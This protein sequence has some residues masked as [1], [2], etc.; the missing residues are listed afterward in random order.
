[1]TGFV[2]PK[3]PFATLNPFWMSNFNFCVLRAGNQNLLNVPS[4]TKQI[5]PCKHTSLVLNSTSSSLLMLLPTLVNCSFHFH[6]Q[7]LQRSMGMR[8]V[9]LRA[10][11]LSPVSHIQTVCI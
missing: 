8:Y 7:T 3:Q 5:P 6:W 1:M 9:L 2:A 10:K 4:A 11:T